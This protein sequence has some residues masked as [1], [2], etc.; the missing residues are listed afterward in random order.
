MSGTGPASPCSSGCWGHRAG[1]QSGSTHC[2]PGLKGLQQ[3]LSPKKLP[4]A[5]RRV[6]EGEMALAPAPPR[7]RVPLPPHV[8]LHLDPKLVW[9]PAAGTLH[10]PARR[11]SSE[12]SAHHPEKLRPPQPARGAAGVAGRHGSHGRQHPHR[13]V[14]TQ[15]GRRQAELSIACRGSLPAEDDSSGASTKSR[16]DISIALGKGTCGQP[17]ADPR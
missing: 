3:T 15:A 8:G 13:W 7:E 10:P 9:D 1:P 2:N 14:R 16:S 4:R 17:E 6:P 11:A 12:G 5:D